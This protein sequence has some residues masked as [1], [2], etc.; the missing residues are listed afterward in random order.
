LNR[1]GIETTLATSPTR[2]FMR[3]TLPAVGVVRVTL[4]QQIRS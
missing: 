3:R 1:W 4:P 2:G